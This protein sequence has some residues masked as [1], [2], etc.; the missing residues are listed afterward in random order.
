[1]TEQKKTVLIVE[2][3][4]STRTFIA[5]ALKSAGY[6]VLETEDKDRY[7]EWIKGVDGVI[8]AFGD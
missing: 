7:E 2:D 4:I 1:M 6:G 3:H 8:F 5:N